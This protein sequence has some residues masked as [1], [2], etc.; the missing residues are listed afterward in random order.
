MTSGQYF[1]AARFCRSMKYIHG[2]DFVNASLNRHSDLKKALTKYEREHILEL[3][4][5]VLTEKG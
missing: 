2:A 4:R 5:E 3:E 1:R